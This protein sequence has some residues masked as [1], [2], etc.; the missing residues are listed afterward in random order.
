MKVGIPTSRKIGRK[1][2]GKANVTSKKPLFIRL[3]SIF[4]INQCFFRLSCILNI[5]IKSHLH[6]KI[7]A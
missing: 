3:L 2:I 1:N 7:T 4:A 5:S 6:F